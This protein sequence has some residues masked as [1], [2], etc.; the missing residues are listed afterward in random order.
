MSQV[1]CPRCGGKQ[2]VRKPERDLR[3]SD[4]PW[5]RWMKCKRC[6]GNGDVPRIVILGVDRTVAG[7]A[8]S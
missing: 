6:D 5:F 4:P 7:E 3:A 2:K 1:L 8:Q